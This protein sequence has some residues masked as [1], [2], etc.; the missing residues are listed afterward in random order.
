VDCEPTPPVRVAESTSELPVRSGSEVGK[1]GS[2][3]DVNCAVLLLC[4][5]VSTF[6]SGAVLPWVAVS[7]FGSGD[8]CPALDVDC[9]TPSCVGVM[10]PST[11][12]PV[13]VVWSGP[14]VDCVFGSASE[15]DD[16]GSALDMES[17]STSRLAVVWGAL[18]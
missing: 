13:V 6:E 10:V 4:V 15:V 7:T 11:A 14:D 12:E 3:L 9:E 18:V 1:A 8:S 2:R 5:V 17:M 16:D